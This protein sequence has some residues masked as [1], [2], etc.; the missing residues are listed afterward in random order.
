MGLYVLGC[1]ANT[2]A[3]FSLSYCLFECC[4][5]CTPRILYDLV[6]ISVAFACYVYSLYLRSNN[7]ISSDYFCLEVGV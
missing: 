7:F 5:F 1:Y 6:I 3:S 4:C 2:S